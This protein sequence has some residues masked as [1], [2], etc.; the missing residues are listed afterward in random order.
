VAAQRRPA[1][2]EDGE[3]GPV[4]ERAALALEPGQELVLDRKSVV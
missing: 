4:D 3:L 2:V 1:V